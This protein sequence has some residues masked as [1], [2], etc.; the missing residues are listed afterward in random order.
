LLL[1]TSLFPNTTVAMA[2]SLT[3]DETAG[4]ILSTLYNK[5]YF[6]ERKVEG[7][8]TY[9][10]HDL[11]REFLLRRLDEEENPAQL[12]ALRQRAA[13][14]LEGAG[15]FSEA[16]DLF[17]QTQDWPCVAR[18]IRA[19]AEALLGQGRW[20]T[21]DAW[22]KGMPEHLIDDDPW[23]LFWHASAQIP[24][25]V[26][27]ACELVKRAYQAFVTTQ[28]EAGQFYAL[29]NAVELVYV[30]GE[31]FDVFDE[32]LPKLEEQLAR[33]TEFPSVDVGAQAWVAYLAMIYIKL[34]K[35]RLVEHGERWL[36][37][38]FASSEL[39]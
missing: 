14:I 12:A 22:F 39:G 33:V 19:H 31:S 17:K 25:D 34:G 2:A 4:E 21:L 36:A 27:A 23:L 9:Q 35:G 37:E 11:F 13:A 26:N 5:Q 18:L 28:D 8:L 20:Q 15:Q 16:V 3:D 29:S 32:W 10:Y 6:I 7:E 30:L 24:I 38:R 1:R